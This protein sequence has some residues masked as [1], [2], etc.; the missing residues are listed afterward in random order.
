VTVMWNYQYKHGD[1]PLAGYTIERAA[2]RGGFGEVYFAV[3]DSGRQ[4]ALKLVQSY[5][6]IELRGISQCMNLKSPHL[7]TIFDVRHNDENRPF[8]IMEYVAGP[9]LR[10]LLD[11]TPAGMGQQKAAFFLREMA[12]GLSFLHDN[13]IV[14]RD[15]KP[16][17][18]FFENGYVKIGDYGLSKLI[19]P[20]QNS[21][22]TVTVGTVHYMAPEIGAGKYDR[23]IDIYALGAVLYEMLT[24]MV[25]FNGASP[26]EVLM[27]HLSSEPDLTNVPEPFAGVIKKAMAKDPT[28][29][30]QSVQEMVEA[31]FG[32]EHVRQSV[33]VFSPDELSVVAARVAAPIGAGVDPAADSPKGGGGARSPGFGGQRGD[34]YDKFGVV[35]EKFGE[36]MA[37]FGDRMAEF[38]ERMADLGV[39]AVGNPAGLS[40]H[41]MAVESPADPINR[42]QRR[43]QALIV[44]VAIG[45]VAGVL[46]TDR[47]HQKLG[48]MFPVILTII[49]GAVGI[50]LAV[51]RSTLC[52][53]DDPSN[54]H[55]LCVGGLATCFAA[56][57]SL[58]FWLGFYRERGQSLGGTWLAIIIPLFSMKASEW[59]DP[60]REHRVSFWDNAFLAGLYGAIAAS[61]FNGECL[62]AGLT[63]IGICLA[64][65]LL[66]PWSTA[67]ARKPEVVPT[68]D[69]QPKWGPPPIPVPPG[70]P[71]SPQPFGDQNPTSFSYIPVPR[72]IR[73]FW[74]VGMLVCLAAGI[75]LLIV[76]GMEADS[77]NFSGILCTGLGAI[78]ISLVLL[79]QAC[80]SKI[81]GWW[82][83]L[84][85]PLLVTVFMI[86]ILFAAAALSGDRLNP[87]DQVL[88]IF[89]I[90]FP[91][92]AMLAV[93]FIPGPRIRPSK[94][95][96]TPIPTMTNRRFRNR[97]RIQSPF[98]ML[99]GIFLWAAVLLTLGVAMN[100]PE[101]IA[102]GLPNGSLRAN[103]STN[104]F[105]GYPQWPELL[106][107]LGFVS[108][109]LLTLLG[110]ASLCLARRG[111]GALHTLRGIA[112]VLLLIF[113]ASMISHAFHPSVW[114]AMAERI[115][116][117]GTTQPA[118]LVADFINAFE[119][120]PLIMAGVIF[121]GGQVLLNWM[122]RKLPAT[123]IE[124]N[125]AA[126]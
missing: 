85:K 53:I 58:P 11:Q 95:M 57:L 54:V 18:V 3:S 96:T 50:R 21:A 112:G 98:S 28:Q 2:G 39:R 110:V 4:V 124:P 89:L 125:R 49:G 105:S 55:R 1:R 116:A 6:Q 65:Q 80:R 41:T 52:L 25:P 38:G 26:S 107:R 36:Q 104:Y 82:K 64:T 69:K 99:S 19:N 103:L 126:A 59:A 115:N 86:C 35:G 68:G 72:I 24:G 70:S 90:V 22:Q 62:V 78:A 30:Y 10:Q 87:S 97:V 66:S 93:I 109:G 27:K 40:S 102:V 23:G 81:Y 100:I 74:L 108:A 83:Y 29:R 15:L 37:K 122:P 101:A 60:N 33:S 121:C 77:N 63:L 16:A 13:G 32:A 111:D 73:I 8:V 43:F 114:T 75:T 88:M 92:V 9:S 34:Y 31:V 45:I 67:V 5:E 79:I 46:A 7:I 17:N 113:S 61:F 123:Q 94:L 118:P 42:G 106:L 44:A 48:I 84:I 20:T 47:D 71:V 91:A 12:K 76:A 51:R 119:R 120:G 14:H 56:L 117:H